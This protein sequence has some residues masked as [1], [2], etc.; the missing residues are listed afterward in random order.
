[1]HNED[2]DYLSHLIDVCGCMCITQDTKANWIVMIVIHGGVHVLILMTIESCVS[3]YSYVQHKHTHNLDLHFLTKIKAH[4]LLIVSG[5]LE[6]TGFSLLF[7][8]SIS[9]PFHFNKENG[10]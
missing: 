7:F 6:I 2:Y 3:T 5:K 10:M 4:E 9:A 8:S 1:M